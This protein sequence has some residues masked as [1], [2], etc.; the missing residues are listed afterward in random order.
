MIKLR[1]LFYCSIIFC[2]DFYDVMI[3]LVHLANFDGLIYKTEILRFIVYYTGQQKNFFFLA[4]TLRTEL[5]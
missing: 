5:G 4:W 2:N 1:N 3:W